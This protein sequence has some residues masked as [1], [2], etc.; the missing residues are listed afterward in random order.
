MNIKKIICYTIVFLF[1]AL[2]CFS[3][4]S[5]IKNRAF[6]APKNI[7]Q[8]KY[9]LTHYLTKP[10]SEDYEKLEVIAYWISSHIA[11]DEYKYNKGVVNYKELNYK[12]DILKRRAG[13]CGD[14]AQLFSDMAHIAGVGKVK[15]VSGYVLHNQGIVKRKYRQRDVAG[16]AG[17]AW[18]EVQIKGR[19]FYVDTT[20]M[21]RDT[22]TPQRRATSLNHKFALNKNGRQNNVNE[23]V[24]EF[25]F[26][27]TPKAEL[28]KYKMIHL[29][30]KFIK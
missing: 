23:N 5:A 4:E 19:K 16:V 27:F 29:Q 9:S 12:Y 26:D 11:Y 21:A 24:N 25:F 7:S 15:V 14:F 10:Y 6:N 8:N 20:F 17:H 18:N 22:V 13:I 2:P 28:K 1:I 3:L 30:D